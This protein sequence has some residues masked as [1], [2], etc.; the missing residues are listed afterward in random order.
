[1]VR[2]GNDNTKVIKKTVIVEKGNET[3]LNRVACPRCGKTHV[4]VCY[5][6]SGACFKCGKVGHVIRDYP[7]MKT[8]QVAKLTDGKPS[9]KIQG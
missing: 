5:L 3:Q 2:K 6:E 9:L 8:E 1:M 4:G 7:T